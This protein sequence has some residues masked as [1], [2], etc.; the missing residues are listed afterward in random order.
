MGNFCGNCESRKHIDNF[1][2]Q[3]MLTVLHN[4]HTTKE[5]VKTNMITVANCLPGNAAYD[6]TKATPDGETFKPE[7]L[8]QNN[9][10]K[11]VKNFL[12][13]YQQVTVL[14]KD[15][16]LTSTYKEILES[17][18][19][20]D[21]KQE[22]M[23][24]TKKLL[25]C[26]LKNKDL[27]NNYLK[28]HIKDLDLTDDFLSLVLTKDRNLSLSG[29]AGKEYYFKHSGP[30]SEVFIIDVK[31][32]KEEYTLAVNIKKNGKLFAGKFNK[33]GKLNGEG[34]YIDRKG[35][36]YFGRFTD[37]Q[38]LFA[39]VYGSDG[40][41]YEGRIMDLKKHGSEQNE[42]TPDYEFVG[43]FVKGKKV[44]GTYYPKDG[45]VV[46]SITIDKENL[47]QLKAD[48][49]VNKNNYKAKFNLEFDNKEST[50][51]GQIIYNKFCDDNAQILFS[52]HLQ[53]PSFQGKVKNNEK[54][55]DGKYNFNDKDYYEGIFFQ[56]NLHKRYENI[57]EKYSLDRILNQNKLD[58]PSKL[59]VFEKDFE[60]YCDKGNLV[61]FKEIV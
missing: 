4:N 9:L 21:K 30:K 42:H 25:V 8:K 60:I 35:N 16:M 37:S 31:N 20:C 33:N 17:E 40:S 46:K 13:D 44:S 36:L 11:D 57:E 45:G 14:C 59:R 49:K 5:R 2:S 58:K 38:L 54:T 23:F 32:K 24:V 19:I 10:N 39:I 29:F 48:I 43:D 47:N 6:E 7:K 15:H 28:S 52:S 55:G 41:I 34:V 12:D 26:L 27:I 22:N 56:N 61:S 50:Y 1:E 53:F 3:F 51:F 18:T